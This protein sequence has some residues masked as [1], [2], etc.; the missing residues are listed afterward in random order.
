MII[1]PWQLLYE[2]NSYWRPMSLGCGPSR[3]DPHFFSFWTLCLEGS[4]DPCYKKG[5]RHPW[6]CTTHD[7]CLRHPQGHQLDT[8]VR[9]RTYSASPQ[10]APFDRQTRSAAGVRQANGTCSADATLHICMNPSS[11]RSVAAPLSGEEGRGG[12]EAFHGFTFRGGGHADLING[13]GLLSGAITEG[14]FFLESCQCCAYLSAL[15]PRAH[16]VMEIL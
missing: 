9:T 11:V 13:R 2:L 1:G 3:L 6:R 5:A 10:L 8:S 14:Y 16:V 15:L 12:G 4:D 7:A